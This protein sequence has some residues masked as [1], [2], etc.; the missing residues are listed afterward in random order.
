MK[1]TITEILN[2]GGEFNNGLNLI[3]EGIRKLKDRTD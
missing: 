2:T 1:N 3:E